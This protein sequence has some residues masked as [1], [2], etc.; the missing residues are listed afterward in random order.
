MVSQPEE[1]GVTSALVEGRAQQK[2]NK[3]KK[4][5]S[6]AIILGL[7]KLAKANKLGI[8]MHNFVPIN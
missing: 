1:K 7:W 4:Y 5:S 6:K 3:T 8:V 2:D